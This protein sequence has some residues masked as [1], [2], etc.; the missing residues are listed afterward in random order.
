MERAKELDSYFMEKIARA[1]SKGMSLRYVARVDVRDGTKIGVS[2]KEVPE[3][4]PIGR[5]EGT[6]NKFVVVTD[7]YAEER[8]YSVEAPGAGLEVTAR[9]IRRDLLHLLPERK[10]IE[11]HK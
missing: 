4:S 5:L 3:K 10:S 8:P 7:A 6:L 9:N 11:H 1:K 2:L